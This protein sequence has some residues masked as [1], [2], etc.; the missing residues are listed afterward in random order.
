MTI[1]K[2]IIT[3]MVVL[4]GS[5]AGVSAQNTNDAN[6]TNTT[7]QKPAIVVDSNNLV[8]ITGLSI[9]N[10]D[11]NK[12]VVCIKDDYGYMIYQNLISE[13]GKARLQYDMSQLTDGCYTFGI[14][15]RYKLVCSKTIVK[16]SEF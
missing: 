8:S 9:T 2:I 7:Y 16:E 1:R 10:K 12:L 15:N 13:Q 3:G 5:F 11:R 14:Y 6:S 4:S